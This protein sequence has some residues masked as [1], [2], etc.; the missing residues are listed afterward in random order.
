MSTIVDRTAD[1]AYELAMIENG[2]ATPDIMFDG[3]W[4]V[5]VPGGR[6][7]RLHAVDNEWEAGV[8]IFVFNRHMVGIGHATLTAMTLDPKFVAATASGLNRQIR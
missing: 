3:W 4:D 6:R 5:L 2:T 7:I 1:A 8:E